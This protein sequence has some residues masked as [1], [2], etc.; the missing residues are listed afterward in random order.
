M[1]HTLSDVPRHEYSQGA[2]FT[3][4]EADEAGDGVAGSLTDALSH[5]RMGG[6]RGPQLVQQ[7]GDSITYHPHQRMLLNCLRI[8]LVFYKTTNMSFSK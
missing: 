8:V 2:S 4:Q 7:V 1:Q 3:A 6:Q 5:L